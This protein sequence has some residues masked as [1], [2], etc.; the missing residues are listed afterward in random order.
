MKRSR[1]S[2]SSVH[3]PPR[4]PPPSP[5]QHSPGTP[6]THSEYLGDPQH[7]ASRL[8]RALVGHPGHHEV[9]FPRKEATV[10][11][12]AHSCPCRGTGTCCPGAAQAGHLGRQRLLM[13][14]PHPG[15]YAGLCPLQMPRGGGAGGPREE[16]RSCSCVFCT[17]PCPVGSLVQTGVGE[18]RAGGG[19]TKL[20]L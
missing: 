14:T 17:S 6:P 19:L 8:L 7:L 3:N 1:W 9:T 13:T 15:Q 5:P 18:D 2:G 20:Y 12:Q 10:G 16:P 4:P 11:A